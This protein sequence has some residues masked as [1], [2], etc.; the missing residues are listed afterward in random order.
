MKKA[1]QNPSHKFNKMV[2]KLEDC[3]NKYEEYT[4]NVT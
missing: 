2:R 1:K 3:F 4:G